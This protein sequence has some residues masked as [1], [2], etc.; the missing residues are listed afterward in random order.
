M[1]GVNTVYGSTFKDQS[2]ILQTSTF[3]CY[4]GHVMRYVIS[5]RIYLI[6][7]LV[8]EYLPKAKTDV[9]DVHVSRHFG[10]VLSTV[11]SVIISLFLSLL[12][13]C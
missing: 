2:K 10:F 7:P 11:D 8:N 5:Q 3:L 12:L 9:I 4:F 13:S 6:Q 1:L